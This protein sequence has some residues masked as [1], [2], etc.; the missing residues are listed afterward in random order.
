MNVFSIKARTFGLIV[1]IVIAPLV[2]AD[3]AN[4][5]VG[6]EQVRRQMESVY[7]VT[8]LRIREVVDNGNP[9]Y[10]VTVMNPPGDFNEA[11]Q[12][13]TVAVDPETGALIPQFREGANGVRHAAPPIARRTSPL[14]ADTP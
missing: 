9:A 11:F 4:A 8:V 3:P 13:N 6:P 14:T 7:G 1:S 2:L 5:Q 12:V 10:A